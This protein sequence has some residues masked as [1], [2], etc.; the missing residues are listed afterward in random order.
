MRASASGA[1][2]ATL[3]FLASCERPAP[4]SEPGPEPPTKA[5]ATKRPSPKP[6]PKAVAKSERVAIHVKNM[7]KELNLT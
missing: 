2:A 7:R 4:P 3:V 1:L 6:A 5:P